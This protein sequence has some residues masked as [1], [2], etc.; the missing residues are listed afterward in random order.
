MSGDEKAAREEAV[1][2]LKQRPDFSI[3]SFLKHFPYKDQK[4]LDGF[5]IDLRKAGLPD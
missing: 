2:V 1:E 3:K 4:I 5:S